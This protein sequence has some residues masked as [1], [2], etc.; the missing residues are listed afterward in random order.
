M[1]IK[2]AFFSVCREAK[3]PARSYV[4]L[5]VTVPF[6]GGPEEG[7]WWGSDR[8]LVAYQECTTEEEAERLQEAV[9]A[10]ADELTK[11]AS[12]AYGDAC[13]ASC[14]WLEAR[15]LDADFLPEVDGPESYWCTVEPTPGE[16]VSRGCR[17]YE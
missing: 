5:Y 12:R 10:L 8:L 16:S 13:A 1:S 11:D 3:Q 9:T 7:G 17:H 4:S 15:G 2:D 6:Y 14:E